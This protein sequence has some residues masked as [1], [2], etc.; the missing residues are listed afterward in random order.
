M[1]ALLHVAVYHS[2]SN[3]LAVTLIRSTPTRNPYSSAE[4]SASP[5]LPL[6]I[7]IPPDNSNVLHP[8][9]HSNT[10]VLSPKASIDSFRRKRDL[11]QRIISQM[12]DEEV[13]VLESRKA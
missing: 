11:G 9:N 1:K 7:L 6:S 4:S 5:P 3:S 12:I 10:A 2:L 8:A 13:D